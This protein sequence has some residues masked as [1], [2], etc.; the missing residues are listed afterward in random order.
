MVGEDGKNS[1]GSVKLK[2]IV[3]DARK[4]GLP[5]VISAGDSII[6]DLVSSTA[7]DI[8]GKIEGNLKCNVINIRD[9][10]VISG[11]IS[12]NYTKISG[13]FTGSIVSKI[14]HISATGIVSADI[15]YG[16]LISEEGAKLTGKCLFDP[17]LLNNTNVGS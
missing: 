3:E 7:I 14:V 2:K 10:G 4:S 6:G 12:A 1:A 15:S 8:F 9:E 5:S 13:A 11:M 16:I 17:N